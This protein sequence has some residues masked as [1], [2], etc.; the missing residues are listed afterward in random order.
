MV[1]ICFDISRSNL[2]LTTSFNR[3]FLCF[4]L[5]SLVTQN[6]NT[7]RYLT[8]AL[9]PTSIIQI[10]FHLILYNHNQKYLVILFKILQCTESLTQYN[11]LH[12]LAQT[13]ERGIQARISQQNVP[14]KES[15]KQPSTIDVSLLTVAPILV[16]LAAGC[17]IGI[18]VLLIERCAHGNI[19]KKWPRGSV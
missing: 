11:F 15:E 7:F 3:G 19:L 10:D 16:V 17:V 2:L 18:F 4:L 9:S 5:F 8:I 13:R 12:R 1:I 6:D 14:S